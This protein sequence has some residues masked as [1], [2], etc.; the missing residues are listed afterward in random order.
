MLLEP[1]G[2]GRSCSLTEER[3]HGTTRQRVRLQHVTPAAVTY[4][5]AAAPTLSPYELALL[6]LLDI[7]AG[8]MLR[9]AKGSSIMISLADP[10]AHLL[11]EPKQRC[12]QQD[13]CHEEERGCAVDMLQAQEGTPKSN[14]KE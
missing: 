5:A 3:G 10:Y 7:P 8:A 14:G 9:L 11:A 13:D 1:I 4:D 6:R 12:T 2:A